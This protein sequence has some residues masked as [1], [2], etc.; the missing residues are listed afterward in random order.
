MQVRTWPRKD[1][2]KALIR[3]ERKKKNLLVLLLFYRICTMIVQESSNSE[4][5][6]HSQFKEFDEEWQS[7]ETL[8]LVLE[9]YVYIC[10]ESH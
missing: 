7:L 5:A 1:P 3:Y 4:Q 2:I 9:R 10:S 8:N 6:Y